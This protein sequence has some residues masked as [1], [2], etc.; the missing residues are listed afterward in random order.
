MSVRYRSLL[1][2]QHHC[3]LFLLFRFACVPQSVLCETRPDV[4]F[5]TLTVAHC[6]RY[7]GLGTQSPA[8]HRGGPGSRSGQSM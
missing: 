3:S 7:P 4:T 2:L 5:I 8:S 1:L 6:D